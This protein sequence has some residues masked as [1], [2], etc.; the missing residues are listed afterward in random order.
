M[1]ESLLAQLRTLLGDASF[2]RDPAECLAYG[3]D[4]SRRQAQPLAV[5]LPTTREQVQAIV[6]GQRFGAATSCARQ[7]AAARSSTPLT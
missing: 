1:S 6:H 5:A 2:L 3:Y 4:N 7:S